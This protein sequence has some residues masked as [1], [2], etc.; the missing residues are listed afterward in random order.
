MVFSDG[1]FWLSVPMYLMNLFVLIK[2]HFSLLNSESHSEI[3]SLLKFLGR[4]STKNYI[5][6]SA[7]ITICV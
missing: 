6:H 7:Y 1:C 3:K 2:K 5:K 4:A